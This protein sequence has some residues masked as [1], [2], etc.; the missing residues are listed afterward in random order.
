MAHGGWHG[1]SQRRYDRFDA[2]SVLGLPAVI[3][4]AAAHHFDDRPVDVGV[5]AAAPVAEAP[6]PGR[7]RKRAA[8][9]GSTGEPVGA[10][11]PLAANNIAVDNLSDHV[12]FFDRPPARRPPVERRR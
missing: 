3:L 1:G 6:R 2:S 9:T 4:S 11:P 12:T 5:A 10:A 7:K 8:A